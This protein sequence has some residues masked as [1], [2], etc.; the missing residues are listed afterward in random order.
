MAVDLAVKGKSYIGLFMVA[1]ATLMYEI[2]LT[3]IFSVTMWYHFAFVAISVAMFGMTA[4]AILVYLNS[5]YFSPEK[6]KQHLCAASLLFAICIIFSFM[7][8]LSI[9][10]PG[11]LSRAISI[12]SLYT[13][14]LTYV[15]IAVPF[16]F[17]GICIC[18]A[19]TKFPK[20]V[21]RLYAAD[22]AG[23]ACGCVL[24][25][26][27]LR[28]TDGPTA[29]FVTAFFAVIGA[30]F[31]AA[32]AGT[33]RMIRITVGMA[34]LIASFI[35]INTGL[36]NKQRPLL[37]LQWVKGAPERTP[38]YEKWNS[39]SRITVG[40]KPKELTKALITG[41][42]PKYTQDTKIRQLELH[43]DTTAATML[44]YF[45][46][47]LSKLEYL[48]HDIVNL[49]H[50]ARDKAKVLVIGSGGGRDILSALVFEQESVV[51][52]EIN[53]DIVNAVNERFADF[54][55]HLDKIPNVSFVADE[56]RSYIS[57]SNDRFDIIQVSLIDTWAATTAGAFIL[58]ENSLYTVE[59]WKIFLKHL[60]DRGIL[61][62]S[63][64][65]FREN[66]GEVYRLTSLAVAALR[67]LGVED[68]QK[69]IIIARIMLGDKA[70]APDGVGTMLVSR[71]PFSEKDVDLIENVI[72]DMGF[73]LVLS[74]RFAIDSNFKTICSQKDLGRFFSEFPI[75]IAPPTDNSPF[76]F[77]MLRLRDIF[78]KGLWEQGSQS[79]NMKAVFVLGSLLIVVTALVLLCII[80]PLILTAKKSALSGVLPLFIYF[81][82][83][84]FGFMLIEISQMQRFIV[85]LGHPTYSLSVVLF[86]LLLSSGLGSYS[87]SWKAESSY[88]S[89]KK[90]IIARMLLLAGALCLFGL[91]TPYVINKFQG[92]IT[93]VRILI[94][95]VILFL[96]GF[97]MGMPF[98]IGMKMAS[99]KSS[100]LT[101]WL[102]GIN[103]ATSVF[104][105]VLAIVIALSLSISVTYWIGFFC[106]CAAF[107]S[108]IFALKQFHV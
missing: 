76:F 82:S 89:V 49:A 72:K 51:G 19:L 28:Y 77:H 101:P 41:P 70:D 29:V 48:K 13:I 39:F 16:V 94:V 31:F 86:A 73:E 12:V 24:L 75:N 60:T 98:P 95:T 92:A 3:R 40:G 55:G 67:G 59:A 97:F 5:G 9:P 34:L 11:N 14:G 58:S 108:I 30:A 46:K 47:D 69:H 107:I 17:S 52:V 27:A 79:F 10:F 63:R 61:T 23:A 43:I 68:V 99:K 88:S 104:A 62:F 2:L 106:Y 90:S 65:Y 74:P 91:L 53:Y 36:V 7:T 93:P 71:Q 85:F 100:S 35:V 80:V 22:L 18:L 21:S 102:W 32:E 38:I 105:S 78:K 4:G 33:K 50:Y 96:L 6:V 45:D 57:R 83:I 84:G 15:V 8:H 37:R 64:W 54:T 66:P 87:T 1:L 81:A 44:T 20:Q 56:A 25:I 103:G 42:S 26:Y